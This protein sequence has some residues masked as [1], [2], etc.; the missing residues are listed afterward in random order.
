LNRINTRAHHQFVASA[1]ATKACHAIIPDSK[2]GCMI[3][4]QMLYPHTCHPDDLQ[5]CEEMRVSLF[6]SDVQAHGYY[7][8]YTDRMLAEKGVTL[9][10]VVGDDEILRQHPVDSSRSV[11]TCPAP[12]A[13]TRKNWKGPKAT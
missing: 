2:V 12:S 4:Y 1:L 7:P 11:I 13:P 9:Q 10:K 5:A 3:S 8:A 6:F